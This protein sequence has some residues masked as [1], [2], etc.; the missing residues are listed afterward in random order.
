MDEFELIRSYMAPLAGGEGLGLQDDAA[1]LSPE[2]GYDLVFTKDT[3][4]EGVHFPEGYFDQD[5]AQ[6]LLRVNLSD[7]AAKGAKPIGYLL[8]LALPKAIQPYQI[9][10]FANGL[11]HVQSLYDFKLFGGDTVSTNGPTIVTATLI[12]NVPSGKMIKRN[13]ARIGD[14][15]WVTGAIGDGLLGLLTVMEDAETDS[16]S[17]E[18]R[19][20]CELAYWRPQPPMPLRQM[21]LN[22][23]SASADVSDG[24]L[25]DLETIC[26]VSHLGMDINL[27]D[28]P[29]SA[30]GRH[31]AGQKLSTLEAKLQ[32]I[33]AGDDY[34]VIFTT[35]PDA[36]SVITAFSSDLGLPVTRIGKCVAGSDVRL[37]DQSGQEIPVPNK[38]YVHFQEKTR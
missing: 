24:L 18:F 32:M 21:L 7:L 16:L 1:V 10:D 31:W 13:G 14:E 11:K 38:G 9:S 28:V 26:R 23:A 29:L 35:S 22:W 15:I 5:V 30:V 8:S 20:F 37:I 33:T 12:G 19:S 3:L 34:Q 2:P 4:V 36:G 25:A 17:P 27:E 6:R